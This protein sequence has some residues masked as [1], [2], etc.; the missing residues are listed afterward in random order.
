MFEGAPL[1]LREFLAVAMAHRPLSAPL[2]HAPA[3]VFG[4]PIIEATSDVL[5]LGVFTTY[6]H[7]ERP[8]VAGPLWALAAPLHVALRRTCWRELPRSTDPPD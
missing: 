2:G 4:W 3:R 8:T 6:A 1:V 7:F 5:H